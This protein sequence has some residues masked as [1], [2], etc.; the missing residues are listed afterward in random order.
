MNL[1]EGFESRIVERDGLRLNVVHNVRQEERR[2]TIVFLHGFP[3]FWIAWRDVFMKLAG[4]HAIIAP[5]LRG[6]NLSD[7]PAD[8]AS[9]HARETVA[10]VMAIAF[11]LN[12][13]RPFIL[14]G[15]DWG[16]SIAYAAAI[17]F[18]RL[19]SKLIIAN[20]VHP[21][22]FQ[23]AIIDDP[24]QRAAS[25]YFHILKAEDAASRMAENGFARTFSM[26]EK[27]SDA[28][29]LTAQ[30]R[31]EYLEAW[32]RPGRMHAMLNWYRASPVIVPGLDETPSPLPPLY[33]AA[34]ED[35]QVKMPHLLIWGDADQALRPSSTEK[36]AEFCP[37]LER[38]VV[39][40]AGHWLLHTHAND[41]AGHIKGFLESDG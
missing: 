14:A 10:D 8:P 3:E 28:P 31:E 30:L 39:K 2:D 16:A 40:G 4:T 24:E 19:V 38:R 6:Y 26:L 7:A 25:Q 41:V 23:E 21:V 29:W 22:A 17:R 37:R 27:F 13:K 11:S 18:P 32:S 5:D 12:G 20:G 33:R 36:L 35:F 9:Y 15:H 1:P 34:R